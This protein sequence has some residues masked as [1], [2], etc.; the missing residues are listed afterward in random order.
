MKACR[1]GAILLV[2]N[3]N[4]C[5]DLGRDVSSAECDL[6]WVTLK[7]WI[8]S[9][10]IA[11]RGE[12]TM[13]R[14]SVKLSNLQFIRWTKTASL[15]KLDEA[16][17]DQQQIRPAWSDPGRINGNFVLALNMCCSFAGFFDVHRVLFCFFFFKLMCKTASLHFKLWIFLYILYL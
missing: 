4:L 16:H 9:H 3:I 13:Q 8:R 2:I 12:P 15:L 6:S 17:P 11:Q 7:F 1:I 5:V 14:F 10:K